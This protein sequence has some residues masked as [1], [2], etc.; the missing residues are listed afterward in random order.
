MNLQERMT[1]LEKKVTEKDSIEKTH[2]KGLFIHVFCPNRTLCKT[3]SEGAC[4]RLKVFIHGLD[5]P[6][7][8]PLGFCTIPQVSASSSDPILNKTRLQ[9]VVSIEKITVCHPF[10]NTWRCPC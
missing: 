6:F 1:G 4:M 3:E 8:E 7:Q 10:T 5:D 2:T 9:T